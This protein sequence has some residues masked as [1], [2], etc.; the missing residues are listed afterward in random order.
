MSVRILVVDDEE[1]IVDLISYNLEKEGFTV[2]KAY[3]GEKAIEL[4][5]TGKP[6]LVI[7]DLMLPGI[8]GLEICRL[9]RKNPGMESLPI[10]MLTAKGDEVDRILGL[11]MGADDYI[12]KPFHVRELIARVRAVLRRS[13]ERP[14]TDKAETFTFKG[15]HIDYNSYEVTV[16]GKNVELGPTE[17]KLLRFLTRHPG[18]VYSRD[19]LL[20][21]VWGD[22]AF[23]EPRTVDVHISRL[24]AEIEKDKNKPQYVLTVRGIGYKFANIRYKDQ[25]K[26]T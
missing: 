7:L 24:R 15:L 18:R 4:L 11:E 9:M 10:I 1:D 2:I 13:E 6:K 17:I 3:N 23:V 20:D 19:Q 12:T 22:E 16:D 25:P 5:K 8:N 14:E 26:I 21:Y